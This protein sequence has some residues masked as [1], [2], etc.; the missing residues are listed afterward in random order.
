[1]VEVASPKPSRLSPPENLLHKW[2]HIHRIA[3]CVWHFFGHRR[4]VGQIPKK[5]KET[6]NVMW[7]SMLWVI[8]VLF[9]CWNLFCTIAN[10]R[11]KCVTETKN[12]SVLFY[13]NVKSSFSTWL[14]HSTLRF[15]YILGGFG[16][17]CAMFFYAQNS[18]AKKESNQYLWNW[19][20][21]R[22]IIRVKFNI[23]V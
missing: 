9:V 17:Q 23:G 8:S 12:V 10:H 20:W 22:L 15:L 2:P 13:R 1:M 3:S 19:N 16:P 7:L 4:T 5:C 18:N 11:I 6:S 14:T 21:S